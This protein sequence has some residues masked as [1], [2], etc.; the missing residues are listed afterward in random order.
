V[1]VIVDDSIDLGFA[2]A[3]LING[4]VDRSE[5]AD[6]AARVIGEVEDPPTYIFVMLGIERYHG[7]GLHDEIGLTPT[8]GVN[9]DDGFQYLREIA[10]RRDKEEFDY[11]GGK[12][13]DS[14]GS[15]RTAYIDNIFKTNFGCDVQLLPPLYL[16]DASRAP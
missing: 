13:P 14:L 3:A 10:V 16:G 7:H 4:T 15:V 12:S 8:T 11:L 1:R 6:W 5:I 2:V 9:S